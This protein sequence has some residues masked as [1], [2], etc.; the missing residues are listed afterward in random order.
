VTSKAPREALTQLVTRRELQ[1]LAVAHHAFAGERC[2]GSREALGIGLEAVEHRDGKHVLQHRAVDVG[3]DATRVRGG[4]RAGGVRG[5]AFLP[6]ELARAQEQARAQLPAHDVGP[7]VQTKRQIAMALHPTCHVLAEHRLAGGSNDRRL[8]EP[9]PA[10]LSHY[11]KFGTES[12]NVLGL[13]PQPALGDEQREVDVLRTRRLDAHVHLC[14]DALPNGVSVRPDHH[15]AADRTR[16]GER[17][18]RE[19]LLIPAGEVGSLRGK[20]P[21]HVFQPT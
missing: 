17:R 12:L 14:L 3:V 5:M 8:L 15:R 2:G 19:H 13:A 10:R 1:R 20:H 21:G 11:G 4:V 6:Q 16:L 9:P 7:L 18:L